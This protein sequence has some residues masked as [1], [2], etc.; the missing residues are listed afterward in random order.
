LPAAAPTPWAYPSTF[1][2]GD[3]HGVL[4]DFKLAAP[5]IDYFFSSRGLR[6][7]FAKY[8][9]NNPTHVNL[10]QS[11]RAYCLGIVSIGAQS[12]VA[13]AAPCSCLSP[14]YDGA[15]MV[16][17]LAWPTQPLGFPASPQRAGW[18][19][20]KQADEQPLLLVDTTIEDASPSHARQE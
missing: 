5:A 19:P 16:H 1:G 10:P 15:H 17:P 9:F 14:G 6:Q 13:A 4:R 2:P 20:E 12:Q 7:M 3:A 11:S 8:Y 18:W